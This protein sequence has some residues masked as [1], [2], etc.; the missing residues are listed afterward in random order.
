MKMRIAFG[1]AG[2]WLDSQKQEELGAS[3]IYSDDILPAAV[4]Q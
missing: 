2:A 3:D 4:R 1:I